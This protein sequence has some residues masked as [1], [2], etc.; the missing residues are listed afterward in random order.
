MATVVTQQEIVVRPLLPRSLTAGDQIDLAAVV[1]NYSGE[2]LVIAASLASDAFELTSPEN[3][4]LTLESGQSS[5]VTWKAIARRE[6]QADVLVRADAESIGD[7]VRLSLPVRPLA[8]PKV[9]TETGVI[10]NEW[11]TVLVMPQGALDISS[12]TIELDRSVA[13][14][15]LSG[16][17]FLTGFPYGCVEQ[18]MSKALPNAVVARAVRDFGISYPGASEDLSEKIAKGLQMLYAMQHDD[19]G[20][21]WWYDDRSHDYQTAWVVFGLAKT[22]EAGYEVD[23]AV[24]DRAVKWLEENLASMDPRTKAFALYAMAEAGHANLEAARALRS[25]EFEL[26][27][28]SRAALALAFHELGAEQEARSMVDALANYRVD[29]GQGVYWPTSEVDGYYNEKTMA[30]SVRTT[31]LVLSAMTRIAPED[32]A[33]SEIARWL[34][35]RRRDYGWGTTNETSFTVLALTDYLLYTQEAQAEPGF[36]VELN[37]ETQAEGILSDDR[38]TFTL[39]IPA[40]SM[41]RGLNSLRIV[42]RA[43]GRLYYVVSSRVYLPEESIEASGR[44]QVSRRYLDAEEGKPLAQFEAGQM[45][46]VVLEVN[47]PEDSYYVLVEDNLPGGL[48][49][50]NEAL[51]V[52]G[53][54]VDEEGNERYL[55]EDLGYNNKEVYGDRV[56]FFVT[57]MDKGNHVFSYFARATRS[58]AFVALPTEAWAMY[59]LDLWGRSAS[60]ELNIVATGTAAQ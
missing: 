42:R 21:G 60:A 14:S 7:A 19:G 39:R 29:V 35:G 59:D 8:V 20:W 52:S 24:I 55:W 43:E 58:G 49:A 1:H 41:T 31:A 36:I 54:V 6:G 53:H 47:A 44:I 13:G 57:E 10:E 37:G 32:P 27:G 11:S 16:L 2:R 26:D 12:V 56:S 15:V 46:K 9:A 48:E 18:I 30:S 51:N 22:A 50:L 38:P 3:V 25:Y 28:F 5:L 34:M 23:D 4:S 40:A 17:E 45:V 33:A